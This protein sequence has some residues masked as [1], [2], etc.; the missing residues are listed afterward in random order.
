MTLTV[1]ALPESL[2]GHLTSWTGGWPPAIPATVTGNPRNA[3]PGWDGRI[4]PLNG[5]V[6]PA[7]RAL[8]G[9]PPEYEAAAMDAAARAGRDL[10]GL[11]WVLPGVLDR[12]DH[13]VYAGTFRWTTA[14]A[15]MAD[16]GEWID[17]DDPLV[18]D[19]LRP[20]GGQVLIARDADGS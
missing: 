7:G 6:D 13:G 17:A 3:L 2:V 20:F 16:A 12:P 1:G 5:V 4:H 14:P 8:I 10:D 19:W 15:Q 9:V 11:L 18:P